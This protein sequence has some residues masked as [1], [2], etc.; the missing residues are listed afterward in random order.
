MTENW[1]NQSRT[2]PSNP[3]IFMHHKFPSVTRR[4]PYFSSPKLA[5]VGFAFGLTLLLGVRATSSAAE[6]NAT[7]EKRL[8]DSVKYLASDELEGRGVGSAGINK[9]AD[10]IAAE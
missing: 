7:V 4:L 3:A 2:A 10:Y 1:G 6:E 8:A 5:A 9:A